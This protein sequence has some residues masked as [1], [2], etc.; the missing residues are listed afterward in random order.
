MRVAAAA[1]LALLAAVP[2]LAGARVTIHDLRAADSIAA[3]TPDPARDRALIDWSKRASLGDLMYVLRRTSASLGAAEAP[4][5]HVALERAA[6]VR[7]TL[8]R[9]L[10]QRIALAAP[11]HASALARDLALMPI[12][13]R[14]YASVFRVA[15]LLPDSGGYDEQGRALRAGL[16]A[17]LAARRDPLAAAM[18]IMIVPT[19]EEAPDQIVRAFD[20]AADSAAVIVGAM[21]AGSTAAIATAANAIHGPVL[22]PVVTDE[23]LGAAGPWVF[24]IGPSEFERGATL[25]RSLLS[26]ARGRRVG[27]LVPGGGTNAMA[28]GF[29]A[30]AESTGAIIALRAT[31]VTVADL[32]A[33]I[34]SLR[35]AGIETLFWSGTPLDTDVLLRRLAEA[36]WNPA[37]CGGA[38][39]DPQRHH[40]ASRAALAGA[41]WVTE[42]WKLDDASQAL[43]DPVLAAAGGGGGDA[44]AIAVRGFLAGRAIAEAV[45]TGALTPEELASALARRA[46]D[47]ALGTA[48]FLGWR[49]GTATI[50]V[51]FFR[52]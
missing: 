41:T 35:T 52:P 46:T 47:P 6:P 31:Y 25:A 11:G 18:E 27:L 19:G 20:R 9:R 48:G 45:T 7:T 1:L 49:S 24:Q 33:A 30:A 22:S 34:A 42:D 28:R 44:A 21:Q 43:L 37:L 40:P 51:L 32:P 16:A 17:G 26:A 12:T 38:E 4:L 14:P 36:K 39:L 10:A 23:R 3:L 50:P 5:L 29:A 15:L 8:R 2:A 13:A